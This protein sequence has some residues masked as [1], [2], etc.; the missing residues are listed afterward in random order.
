[1]FQIIF[2]LTSILLQSKSLFIAENQNE[3]ITNLL[4]KIVDNY[5]E[6]SYTQSSILIITED[7]SSSYDDFYKYIH[8]KIGTNIISY[9]QNASLLSAQVILQQ[10]NTVG[11]FFYY[12]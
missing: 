8:E 5:Y 7:N 9:K 3:D 2:I 10:K 6:K 11:T 12:G 1:M 4:R